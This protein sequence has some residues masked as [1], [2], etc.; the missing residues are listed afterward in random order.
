VLGTPKAAALQALRE[1]A[2]L[3]DSMYGASPEQWSVSTGRIHSRWLGRSTSPPAGYPLWRD[4]G[5][6]ARA[7]S[8]TD[9]VRMVVEALRI[10]LPRGRRCRVEDWSQSDPASDVRGVAVAC[11][12]R[13]IIIALQRIQG[14]DG[15]TVSEL[16]K[17]GEH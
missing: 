4:S 5:R 15:F 13:S 7:T 6:P 9:A 10:L 17:A 8:Q 2:Y 11:G 14:H 1:R 3:V 16:L 12:P